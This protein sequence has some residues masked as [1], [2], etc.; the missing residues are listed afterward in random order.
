LEL[1]EDVVV[2]TL[3]LRTSVGRSSRLPAPTWKG[4]PAQPLGGVVRFH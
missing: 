1:S 3:L 4:R 2:A